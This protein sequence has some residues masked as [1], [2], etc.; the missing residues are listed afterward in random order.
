MP[1]YLV[2]GGAGFIGRAL[3][4]SL[5]AAGHE[6]R[7]LDDLSRDGRKDRL[8]PGV[9]LL[10]GDVTQEKM[11]S[12]AMHGVDGVFHLA[13]RPV[14]TT[15]QIDRVVAM[16]SN[17]IGTMKTVKAARDCGVPMVMAS[18]AR[19]YQSDG[20][21]KIRESHPQR[22][23]DG[24][25]NDKLAAE[26]HARAARLLHGQPVVC[27]R[28]FEVYGEDMSIDTPYAVPVRDLL[29]QLSGEGPIVIR[30]S[31]RETIDLLH[32]EDAAACLISA[33]RHM[34]SAP[35]VINACT[36]EAT[37][38]SSFSKLLRA[39]SP[40]REIRHETTKADRWK[41][42]GVGDPSLA[43]ERL[44]LKPRLDLQQG[45]AQLPGMVQPANA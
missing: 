32:V 15:S 22:P 26:L 35:P 31:A 6:V 45:L 4:R 16:H 38:L 3:C 36:G 37:T 34:D 7:V 23:L 28:L 39:C 25:G 10:P 43:R 13:A 11:L 14:A 41:S 42:P 8:P 2:T 33:M 20:S 40:E 19:V 30:G 18:S 27:V 12:P 9:T 17:V 29:R 44:S 1:T 5:L 21:R 24:Y